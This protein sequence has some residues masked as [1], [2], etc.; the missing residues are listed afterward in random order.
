MISIIGARNRELVI[1]ESEI[2]AI[3][4]ELLITT[5]DGSYG[6]KGFV[7]D[8]L[9]DLIEDGRTIDFVLAIGPVPDDAGGRRGRLVRTA[10]RPW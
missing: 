3:S 2:G 8:Q 6:R 1:L 5:D 10:S 4:D 9:Q 7:T